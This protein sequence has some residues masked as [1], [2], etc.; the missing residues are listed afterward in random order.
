VDGTGDG[1]LS[2]L[3]PDDLRT[4]D[5]LPQWSPDGS[6]IAFSRN[7][8]IFVMNADGSGKT[9]LTT[10]PAVDFQ[11]TWSPDGRKIVWI[12]AFQRLWIMNHDGTAPMELTFG[13]GIDG[14]T[15]ALS[16]GN[17]DPTWSPNGKVLAFTRRVTESGRS[18]VYRVNTDGSGGL[19]NLTGRLTN[20]GQEPQ[21]QP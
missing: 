2:L 4:Q 20:G 17:E 15:I 18:D 8:D 6:K 3:P 10:D 19:L 7:D 12:R 14:A 11:P 21:W 1:D 13:P 5:L 16:G 9:R